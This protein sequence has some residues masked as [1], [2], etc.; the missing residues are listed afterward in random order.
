METRILS[1]CDVA[2]SMMSHRPYRQAL[3]VEEVTDA[4]ARGKGTKFDADAVECVSYLLGRDL[5]DACFPSL[6]RY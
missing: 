2:D 1:V 6:K 4:L 3:P 5:N